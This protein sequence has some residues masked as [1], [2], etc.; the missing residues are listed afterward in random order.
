MMDVDVDEGLE[1]VGCGEVGALGSE[2]GEN[3]K[4][5][6]VEGFVPVGA[7][8]GAAV[9]DSAFTE[10]AHEH[11]MEDLRKMCKQG[12]HDKMCGKCRSQL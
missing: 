9:L 4:P 5:E 8:H 6:P 7:G 3:K 11:A 2:P 12:L 10:A 1:C